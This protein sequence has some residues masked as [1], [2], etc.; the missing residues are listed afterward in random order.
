VKDKK[1]ELLPCPFCGLIPSLHHSYFK[2][3]VFHKC[4]T[5]KTV[6]GLGKKNEVIAKWNTR[7]PIAQQSLSDS[8]AKASTSKSAPKCPNWNNG[9]CIARADE[10]DICDGCSG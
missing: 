4:E 7:T 10:I 3:G 9:K 5:I 8:E 2:W 1:V 6:I